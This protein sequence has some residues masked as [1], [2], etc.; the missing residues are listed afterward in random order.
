[1]R[2]GKANFAAIAGSYGEKF[3]EGAAQKT[4]KAIVEKILDSLIIKITLITV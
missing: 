3:N 2:R 1:L 4:E